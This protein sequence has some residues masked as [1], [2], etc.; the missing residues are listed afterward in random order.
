MIGWMHL[1]NSGLGVFWLEPSIEAI[2]AETGS[3]EYKQ[4]FG[5][6]SLHD[7]VTSLLSRARCQK[8]IL[9]NY[10]GQHTLTMVGTIGEKKE[11][12][13]VIRR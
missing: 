10:S 5:I 11:A 12:D 3:R 1:A 13:N 6:V 9:L 2:F 7:F 4:H 8:R